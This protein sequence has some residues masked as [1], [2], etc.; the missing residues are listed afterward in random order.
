MKKIIIILA[1]VLAATFGIAPNFIGQRAETEIK[2]IYAQMGTA[3]EF[4]VEVTEYNRGW[5]SS[6]AVIELSLNLAEIDPT[7]EENFTFTLKNTMKHGPVLTEVGGFGLGLIDI[8]ATMEFPE[9][10]TNEMPEFNDSFNE[11]LSLKSR[12]FFDGSSYSITELKEFEFSDEGVNITLNPAR[13]TGTAS[14]DGMMTA[15]GSW[16]GLS[17]SD[18]GTFGF[19]MGEMAMESKSNSE[20]FD[21]EINVTEQV[22]SSLA[23]TLRPSDRVCVPTQHIDLDAQMVHVALSMRI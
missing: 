1:V 4:S 6:S 3:P 10:I 7:L 5:F 22:R 9:M 2:N 12:M 19:T 15:E 16:D 21:L 13:F 23:R 18:N 14:Q 17:I 20:S 8:N 11:L